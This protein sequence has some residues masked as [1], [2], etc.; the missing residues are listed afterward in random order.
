M[1]KP[2]WMRKLKK[3]FRHIFLSPSFLHT[4]RRG[5]EY[6]ELTGLDTRRR[7]LEHAAAYLAAHRNT[8]MCM[9][10]A[11]IDHFTL[12][13]QSFGRD[14]GDR[15]LQFISRQLHTFAKDYGGIAGY[16]GADCFYYLCP[17]R[18]ELFA[19]IEETALRELRSRDLEVGYAVKCGVYRI[20]DADASILDIC[21]RAKAALD[22]I[23]KDYSHL[24]AWYDPSMERSAKECRLIREVESG[25][26]E[27]EFTFYLQPKCNMLNGKVVGSEGAAGGAVALPGGARAAGRTGPDFPD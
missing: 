20:A 2:H 1:D 22:S 15:Y 23:R 19:A 4:S 18:P 12:Y 3:R 11:D 6:D 14:A 13:N 16:F 9:L 24:I 17:D 5:R 21:D 27:R 10:C 25:L 26:R 8:G 7:F